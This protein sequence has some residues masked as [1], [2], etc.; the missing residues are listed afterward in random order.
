MSQPISAATR[1]VMSAR[2]GLGTVT[3][4]GIVSALTLTHFAHSSAGSSAAVPVSSTTQ[5]ATF[6][7]GPER[8]VVDE[9]ARRALGKRIF[10]D[11]NLSEP[12][13]T[14]CA[15]CHDPR[16]GYAGNNGS[17]IGVP[18]GSRP[19]HF[20]ARNTPSVMY[21]KY[22]RRFHLHWEEDAPLVDAFGGFFW[23]GRVD[24]LADVPKQPLLNPDE[25]NNASVSEIARKV[26]ESDYGAQFV[27]EFGKFGDSEATVRAVGEAL[28]A[29]LTS[30]ELAPFSSKYDRY[31]QHRADLS[32]QEA[33]GLA[34]FKD[35]AKG[36]C[37]ACHR[38][39]DTIAAPERSLFTDYGFDAVGLPRNRKLPVN[40]DSKHFDLG[41]CA[42]PNPR[43]RSDSSEFCGAFRTPSLRNVALRESFMHNGVFT[44]LRDV[45]AFYASRSVTPKRW[46]AGAEF[47]D[48]PAEYREY[49]NV[50]RAPYNRHAGDGPALSE[51]EI[52]DIV[53][54]LGT[55]TDA[56]VP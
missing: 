15:S 20:A 29:Y 18:R 34:W 43:F 39:N 35:S 40:A 5:S 21:L 38:L 52:D 33:R 37:S 8:A 26:S 13:G 4:L 42:R 16:R 50:D 1:S 28:A 11:K 12:V 54:F 44:S 3:V 2:V 36:G 51:G 53:A 45:V 31:I 49:V 56:P 14:S 48:V 30:P 9:A 19:G 27:R 6:P 32:A 46:Y 22:T 17:K 23:D 7:P 55:L 25:M 41:L 10:F 24:N 47:D